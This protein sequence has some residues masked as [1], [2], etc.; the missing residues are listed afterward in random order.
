MSTEWHMIGNDTTTLDPDFVS[1]YRDGIRC[2]D[3]STYENYLRVRLLA[4]EGRKF[5]I[6]PEDLPDPSSMDDS[7]LRGLETHCP[8]ALLIHGEPLDS[9]LLRQARQRFH[10]LDTTKLV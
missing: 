1:Y 4:S 8:E 9:K 7:W 2:F 3:F 10:G 6:Y 5:A